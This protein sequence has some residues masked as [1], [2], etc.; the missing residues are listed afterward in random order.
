ML[1][2]SSRTRHHLTRH[3][4][5]FHTHIAR[6]FGEEVYSTLRK[7][8]GEA[9]FLGGGV[10]IVCFLYLLDFS[11]WTSPVAVAA[12]RVLILAAAGSVAGK[13]GRGGGDG[14]GG[15]RNGY[16]MGTRGVHEGYT[17]RAK[18]HPALRGAGVFFI[19]FNFYSW[20]FGGGK[21]RNGGA[22]T[23]APAPHFRIRRANKRAHASSSKL[24][25]VTTSPPRATTVDVSETFQRRFTR[26]NTFYA[27]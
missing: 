22:R 1:F 15:I 19:I 14:R 9:Y 17:P 7:D 10:L 8:Q 18:S 23:V 13:W 6:S 26:W 11:Y 27:V 25:H 16:R 2:V 12:R 4:H 3:H 24:R 21:G 20:K 5:A